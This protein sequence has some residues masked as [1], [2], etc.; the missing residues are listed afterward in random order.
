MNKRHA[1]YPHASLHLVYSTIF[2]LRC[3]FQ[4]A[5]LVGLLSLSGFVLGCVYSKKQASS[6]FICITGRLVL[7]SDLCLQQKS[8]QA[9][10]LSV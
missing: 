4:L 3:Q 9:S 8:K 1:E 2:T 5:G 6:E 7:T 10:N